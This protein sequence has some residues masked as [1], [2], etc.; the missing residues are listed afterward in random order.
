MEGLGGMENKVYK[1]LDT[2]LG[3]Y[4]PDEHSIDKEPRIDK[5]SL[6]YSVSNKESMDIMMKCAAEYMLRNRH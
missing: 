6:L 5:Y 3:G 1:I 4:T 2:I